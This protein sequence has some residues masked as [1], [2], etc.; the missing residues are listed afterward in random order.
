MHVS[1]TV[2]YYSSHGK[3][4]GPVSEADLRA[5][6]RSGILEP[7][8]LVWCEGMPDWAP[9]T[10]I[11]TWKE[12]P[13]PP[14]AGSAPGSGTGIPSRP[15][16][17]TADEM[18]SRLESY[19][20]ETHPTGPTASGTQG[21]ASASGPAPGQS[22]SN[23]GAGT[24]GMG[25]MAGAGH[26]SRTGFGQPAPRINTHLVKAI[27]ATLF[28]CM[29][30]GIVAIVKAAQANSLID[31]GNYEKAHKSA[32]G[33][34]AWANWSIGLGII[35]YAFSIIVGALGALSEWTGM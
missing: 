33:A 17:P 22:Q 35:G 1:E 31:S 28:C 34:N 15:P 2:W 25:G 32:K 18:A 20:D 4:E 13:L 5:Q 12:V 10:T 6:L 21:S 9:A 7:D 29:P 26:A 14:P 8:T 19:S 24:S 11:T 27:L 30:L 16:A 23:V 3:P